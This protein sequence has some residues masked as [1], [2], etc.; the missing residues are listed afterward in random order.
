[1][2]E[3]TPE[4][5][6]ET[7]E[8]TRST[9]DPTPP[10]AVS[11]SLVK[12]HPLQAEKTYVCV[13]QT[14]G[15]VVTRMILDVFKFYVIVGLAFALWLSP[16]IR[17]PVLS[18]CRSSICASP[19][20]HAFSF[21]R[22]AEDVIV[23]HDFTALAQVHSQTL[24]T[25]YDAAVGVWSLSDELAIQGRDAKQLAFYVED[26]QLDTR[27]RLAND[28]HHLNADTKTAATSLNKLGA[29]TVGAVMR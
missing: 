26:S 8:E 25:L 22:G 17:E 23:M 7:L 4:S 11:L 16:T 18:A 2:K 9:R 24:S 20:N 12:V 27:S 29:A 3:Q 21:C 19:F 28:L 13:D 6:S 14:V 15:A 1:M 5:D 10:P